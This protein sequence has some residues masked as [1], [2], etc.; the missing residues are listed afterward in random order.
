MKDIGII[1][2]WWLVRHAPVLL[3]TIYGQMDVTAD[4]SDVAA[5]K[6]LADG[7]PEKM[8]VV[9]SDLTRCTLTAQK[10]S[11][12]QRRNMEPDETQ[13]AFR[14]QHFGD[15]QG[16]SYDEAKEADPEAYRHFW[17]NSADHS[18]PNGESFSDV[19]ARVAA[20]RREISSRG[21]DDNILVVAHAGT[22]RAFLADALGIA[23]KKALSFA[24]E[25]LSLTKLT[26]YKASE[27]EH[28]QINWINRT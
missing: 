21:V 15:W 12:V 25:P 17:N 10:I 18:P 22:V 13:S 19:T 3:N 7:L 5:F 24:I 1:E 20:A 11:E 9:S 16:L 6:R 23:P 8:F 2:H 14:E 28:W 4:Y 27:E 26:L